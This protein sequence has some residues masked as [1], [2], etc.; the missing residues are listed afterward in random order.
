M[1]IPLFIKLLS[2][3]LFE[4]NKYSKHRIIFR[5]KENKIL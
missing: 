4:K 5:K 2:L 1:Y 3:I